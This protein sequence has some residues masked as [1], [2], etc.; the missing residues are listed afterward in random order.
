VGLRMEAVKGSYQY[1]RGHFRVIMIYVSFNSNNQYAVGL[2]TAEDHMT[3][4]LTF[5]TIELY[6]DR[7][8][9]SVSTRAACTH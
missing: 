5:A 3:K 1:I 2:L 4:S 9:V 8:V 6:R 7:N